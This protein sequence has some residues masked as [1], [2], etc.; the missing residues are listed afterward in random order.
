MIRALKNKIELLIS[1]TLRECGN[2]N[3][4][5]R[6]NYVSFCFSHDTNRLSNI[7]QHNIFM[8]IYNNH[9]KFSIVINNHFS[10]FY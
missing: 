3:E 7:N 1:I 2:F 9:H 5:S 6:T 8:T 10:T 4:M